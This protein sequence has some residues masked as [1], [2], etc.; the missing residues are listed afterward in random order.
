[1]C[2][3]TN[4]KQLT[5]S[6]QLKHIWDHCL[7]PAINQNVWQ[8]ITTYWLRTLVH[9]LFPFWAACRSKYL[10]S[11]TDRQKILWRHWRLLVRLSLDTELAGCFSVTVLLQTHW[12]PGQAVLGEKSRQQLQSHWR[13]KPNTR[14]F[15]EQRKGGN[16]TLPEWTHDRNKTIF[17]HK[18]QTTTTTKSRDPNFLKIN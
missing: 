16:W 18:N 12:F 10:S 11:T 9:S 3:A 2:T 6:F 15:S 7:S 8:E 1:M 14:G 5:H 17:T 4:S 13:G